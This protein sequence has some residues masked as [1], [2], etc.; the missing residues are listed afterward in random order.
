MKRTGTRRHTLLA[1]AALTLARLATLAT[2][3]VAP[4]AP[5]AATATTMSPR[6]ASDDL[7]WLQQY[8]VVWSSQ[9][10]NSSESMP[11]GGGDLGLNVW[12]E[13]GD[14]LCYV[15]RSGSFDE[16]NEYLKLG[17]LRVRLDPSPFTAGSEFRQELKLR[18]GC[19]EITGTN[20]AGLR[21]VIRVWT[22][23][24]RSIVHVDIEA[25]EPI[26][27]TATYEN[28]R[29]RDEVLPN[30]ATRARFGCFSWDAFPGEVIRY[31]DE[32]SHRGDSVLFYHRNRDDRLLFDYVVR[33]QGLESVRSQLVDT[34]KGRTFGGILRGAGFVADGTTNG[35]Y[36]LTP[37]K[38]WRLRSAQPAK[39]LHLELVT[40]LAQTDT[41]REWQDALVAEANEATPTREEAREAARSWWESFWQRSH[42][43]ITPPSTERNGKAWQLA[44]NYQ[45]FRYQLGCNAR[46]EYPTKF[47][48]GNF[49]FDPSLVNP[50]YSNG[51][52]WRAWGGGSFTAQNQRLLYWPMLKSGD[53]DLMVPQLEFYRRALPSAMA[54][55]RTYWGHDGC[56][57]TEHSETFGLPI[58]A[59][60]GWSEPGATARQRGLEVP[61]GDPRA[62]G[63]QGY[64][65]V[66]ERGVQANQAVAYHW[67]SQ[68]E[69][70]YMMMERHRFFGGAL[71]P[72]LPFIRQSVRFFDEHYQAYERIRTGKPLDAEGRL[73][74]FP[75]TACESYRGA[76]NPGVI[77]AGL[78]ACLESL[79]SLD[80]RLV[81]PAEKEYYRGFVQRLPRYSYAEVAGDRILQ[82]A[83]SWKRYQNE[84]CPQFYPLFPFDRFALGRDDLEVFR[85]TWKR[86]TFPKNI[87]ASWHYDGILFARMGLTQAAADYNTRKLQDGPRRFP[88]FW[89]PGKDWVPDHNWGGSG[90]IGLQEMLMQTIGKQILLLP[91]WP[92]EWDVD[93]KLHAPE[94]TVIEAQVRGGTIVRLQ[95]TPESRRKDVVICPPQPG[96]TAAAVSPPSR[97]P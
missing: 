22:E 11:C 91:A 77:I 71:A 84:E 34:Q 48:G 74:I 35:K 55:V 36:L 66:V 93:F 9:S 65:S 61:F 60:W 44:R 97:Q 25:S 88:T 64:N 58:A 83:E 46:G 33:Q 13:N 92:K 8:D 81:P 15:Q 17:R 3:E 10:A 45:L 82:P 20:A 19:V 21:T 51:P 26:K 96:P 27:A 76:K 70:A 52:D 1:G 59:G 24:S 62:D 23:V 7:A 67:A 5:L 63:A 18:E 53:A 85:N 56:L 28:W 40:H 12:V 90:M 95:V 57:F 80:D 69:F 4:S 42:I 37:F 86:G 38:G 54:R 31:H 43:V 30:D 6:F 50:K 87:V 79:L 32:V 16:N 94:Q 49:T 2:A 47:N 78:S 75:S 41:F 68:L 89:G 73:V 29:Q 72:Y 14:L 39:Q